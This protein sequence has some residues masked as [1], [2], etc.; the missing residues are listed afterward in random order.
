MALGFFGKRILGHQRFEEEQKSIKEGSD[1]YGSK[2]L[3]RRF[4]PN[5]R[6]PAPP[7]VQPG[8]DE[9][10]RQLAEERAA[11]QAERATL[12]AERAALASAQN[13]PTE[14]IEPEVRTVNDLFETHN[15]AD[16]N[17][18]G[19]LSEVEVKDAL[20]RQPELYQR[21]L[22]LEIARG[23]GPRKGVSRLLLEFEQARREGGPRPA[24]VDRL[25]AVLA[26]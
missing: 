6:L 20:E 22:D 12:A 11:L 8:P 9:L 24:V 13:A 7:G 21:L 2:V 23:K 1:I 19:Y 14:P 5:A 4:N 25:S 15:E 18:D 3:G 16:T 10:L 17:G 26:G